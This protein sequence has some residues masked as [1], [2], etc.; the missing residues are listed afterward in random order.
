MEVFRKG[1]DDDSSGDDKE[2]LR[3]ESLGTSMSTST[4]A[5]LGTA[6]DH[7]C[8]HGVSS[9]PHVMMMMRMM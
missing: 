7:P 4:W 8:G 9:G 5:P 6:M 2:V 1:D 3:V